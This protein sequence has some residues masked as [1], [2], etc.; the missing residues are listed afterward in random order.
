MTKSNGAN[1][2]R[3]WGQ[4]LVVVT[5]SAGAASTPQPLPLFV[6]RAS[7][8]ARSSLD[9]RAPSA[10]WQ[11]K[12]ADLRKP[13]PTSGPRGHR[14]TPWT[15]REKVFLIHRSAGSDCRSDCKTEFRPGDREANGSVLG[16]VSVGYR[17]CITKTTSLSGAMQYLSGQKLEDSNLFKSNQT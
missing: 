13:R 8:S 5:T 15:V 1:T 3:L 2:V 16:S 7:V 17:N 10:P 12:L 6:P 11:P 9:L 4:Q 14:R